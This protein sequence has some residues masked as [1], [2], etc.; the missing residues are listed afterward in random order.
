MLDPLSRFVSC[1]NEKLVCEIWLSNSEPSAEFLYYIE[2]L[3][4]MR[5]APGLAN[6]LG[7]VIDASRECLK[8]YLIEY[9]NARWRIDRIVQDP[10]ISW[11][12]RQKWTKQHV[13]T[14]TQ[15][16]S[17][18]FVAGIICAYRMPVVIDNSDSVQLSFSKEIA[19]CRMLGG[20]YPPEYHHLWEASTISIGR[21]PQSPVK[22]T[23]QI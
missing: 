20:Y 5:G 8:S 21:L 1:I 16:H 2:L 4:C 13:E 7:V 3:H 23:A 9:P 11:N 17:K 10:S 15:L 6:L 22:P 12:R 14:V 18:G 19:I